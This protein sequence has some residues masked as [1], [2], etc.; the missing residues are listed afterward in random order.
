MALFHFSRPAKAL[1]CAGLFLLPGLA[2]AALEQLDRI[3]AIVNDDVI[4]ATEL[5]SRMRFVER[6]LESSG[7]APPPRDVIINQVMERLVLDSLQ[8]QM[9]RRAGVRISEEELTRAVEA[10]AG[11]NGLDIEGFQAVLAQDGMTYREFRGQI[12]Q[13]MIIARVQQ[14]RVNDRIYISP[15]ELENFLASPVGRAATEDEF[16]VGHILL[17][18]AS[19]ATAEAMAEAEARAQALVASLR[20]GE[21]FSQAAVANSAGQRAL[22]GGDLGWRKPGQLPSLFAEDVLKADLGEVLNPIRSASGFHIVKILDQRGASQQRVQQTQARHILIRPTEIRSDDEAEMIIRDLH[23]RL[24]A[25]EDF[26]QVA[27]DFS[28][29]PGSALSGGDLG[30]S[31]PGQMVPA[32]E[33]VMDASDIG[34]LSEPFRSQFG[35]HVLEVLDRREQDMSEEVKLRQAM[36]I[37][38]ERRFDEEL[39]AWLT[40]IREEAYV[41]LKI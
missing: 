36:R 40:E 19:D 38:R 23:Q 37:L 4:T 16:R 12:R 30:W 10:I 21:D 35:W 14:N 39:E 8:M 29:D 13:E 17:A 7:M 18:V 27:R 11:Q 32:F 15:Q 9:G 20:E 34:A 25:G 24:L 28:D 31:M 33:A 6:Q 22:E 5:V 1:L 41:E 3:V 26:A 2:G